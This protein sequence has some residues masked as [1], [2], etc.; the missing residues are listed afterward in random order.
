MIMT[1]V[2]IM[3]ILMGTL[4][5]MNDVTDLNIVLALNTFCI[6]YSWEIVPSLLN[7]LQL[8]EHD[9]VTCKFYIY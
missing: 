5:T 7:I 6:L 2:Y 9:E 4:W 8:S 1:M 3:I